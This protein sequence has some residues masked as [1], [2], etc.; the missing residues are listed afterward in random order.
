VPANG[1]RDPDANVLTPEE[2]ARRHTTYR[3]RVLIGPSYRAGMEAAVEHDASLPPAEL[4]R[5]AYGSFAIAWQVKR[6]RDLL[7]AMPAP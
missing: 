4:A 1:L 3:W 7:G 2:L 5:W 6:D